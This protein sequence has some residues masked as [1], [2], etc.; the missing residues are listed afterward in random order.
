MINLQIKNIYKLFI[1]I[2]LY[3][4][5]LSSFSSFCYAQNQDSF[6][7]RKSAKSLT[8][9]KPG[10]YARILIWDL[11]QTRDGVR[12][13]DLSNNFSI[14]PDGN[15]V[16]PLIGEVSLKGLTPY[17]ASQIL[18]EKYK[19]YMHNPYIHVRPLIRLTL[20]GAFNKP[21]SYLIDPEQS[22]WDLIAMADGPDG[23]CDLEAMW[24]E[25]GG[26]IV[27]E[28]LL[29]SFEEGYSLE[30]IGIESGDQILAPRRRHWNLNLLLTVFNL[31]ATFALIYIR[32]QD[33]Y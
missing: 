17:E 15:V 2:S 33:R 16:L 29:K 18:K 5:V 4:F 11:S 27:T 6:Q 31:V 23:D 28:S 1:I 8:T 12:T 3:F 9:F 32:F 13:L 25:R 22:L 10:D 30:E 20:Q 24:I 7:W 19:A 26:E 21:G 14:N